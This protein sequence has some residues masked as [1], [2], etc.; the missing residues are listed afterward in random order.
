M[1]YSTSD[2]A[3]LNKLYFCVHFVHKVC[4]PRLVGDIPRHYLMHGV[5]YWTTNTTTNRPIDVQK[6]A[7]LRL[8]DKQNSQI[9]GEQFFY[10]MFGEQGLSVHITENNE[11]ILIGAPGIFTWKGSVVRYKAK[12]SE[13]FGGL[14]RRDEE[15]T[16]FPR[17]RQQSEIIEYSSD[18]PNPLSWNQDDN[19]YFGF[20]I[21]SGYFDG[22]QSMKL[23]YVATAP[24]ANA[25]QGEAYIFDIVDYQS[26]S[27]KTIKIYY[28]FAGEQFGEYFGYS[29]IAEDFD[30]DGFTDIAIG[31][32]FNA[33]VGT[34]ENGA[35][36]IYRNHGSASRF[37]LDK[38][39]RTDYELSGRFGTTMSRVGDINQDGFKGILRRKCRKK[40]CIYKCAKMRN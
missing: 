2:N 35:V 10:Y 28:K 13:D 39:L 40:M 18:I 9:N 29:V 30:G 21:S 12:I 8:K 37:E 14:S 1:Y 20:A 3:I 7:S 6:I 4:A 32:P 34:H 33:K 27:D 26:T 16:S 25:Q 24:Q 36:Y 31:A 15:H 19:S 17:R 5:C 22:P 38:V 23:L 11:E